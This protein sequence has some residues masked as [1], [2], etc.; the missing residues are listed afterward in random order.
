MSFPSA[1]DSFRFDIENK[2][3]SWKT[4]VNQLH[5]VEMDNFAIINSAGLITFS[6]CLWQIFFVFCANISV[7][8][9][10]LKASKS[11]P[12]LKIRSCSLSLPSPQSESIIKINSRLLLSLIPSYPK[13]LLSLASLYTQLSE[14]IT[15]F[16][17]TAHQ[18]FGV[19]TFSDFT[20]FRRV[21]SKLFASPTW[22]YG[23]LLFWML[24]FDSLLISIL[25]SHIKLSFDNPSIEGCIDNFIL[26]S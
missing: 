14:V 7:T 18:L 1:S 16:G 23:W 3:W 13:L 17:F 24:E 15:V 6:E 26:T 12:F 25:N 22:P 20:A 11:S 4:R 8:I 2:S 9:I 21:Y 10:K 19:I 5:S